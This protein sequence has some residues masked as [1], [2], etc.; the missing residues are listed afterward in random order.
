MRKLL[1]SLCVCV[2]LLYVR[3]GRRRRAD[4]GGGGGGSGYRIKNKNPIQS[5][6]EKRF[7]ASKNK[8]LRHQ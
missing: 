7:K 6:G 2:K 8:Y 1:L 5:C 3:D 4:G